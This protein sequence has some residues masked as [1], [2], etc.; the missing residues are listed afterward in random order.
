MF[1]FF[2]DLKFCC[3]NATTY[4]LSATRPGSIQARGDNLFSVVKAFASSSML[5]N[6]SERQ[7]FES[8]TGN[9]SEERAIFFD[10]MTWFMVC[11]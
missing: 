7:S 11:D 4:Q 8:S 10:Y 6:T 9:A 5:R 2:C 3:L 1:F